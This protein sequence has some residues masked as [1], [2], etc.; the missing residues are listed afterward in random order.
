MRY[1]ASSICTVLIYGPADQHPPKR[2]R[3][4]T[5]CE[6]YERRVS[7]HAR[8]ASS[9]IAQSARAYAE[10]DGARGGRVG[11]ASGAARGWR[12]QCLDCA[13]AEDRGGAARFA[14]GTVRCGGGNTARKSLDPAISRTA[15]GASRGGRNV[16]LVARVWRRR[17]GATETGCSHRIARRG[18]IHARFAIERGVEL[19][20]SN[21]IAR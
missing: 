6:R 10:D 9:G 4:A 20:L 5:R 2:V 15:S 7:A 8:E 21:W 16:S 19:P 12:R 11:A 3:S 13:V 18:K 14:G 17:S 1:T